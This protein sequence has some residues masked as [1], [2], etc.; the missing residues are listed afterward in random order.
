MLMFGTMDTPFRSQP[1]NRGICG[2]PSAAIRAELPPKLGPRDQKTGVK[3]KRPATDEKSFEVAFWKCDAP[4]WAACAVKWMCADGC[5]KS[6][7][8]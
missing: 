7:N 4:A 1:F 3:T 6:L 8:G 2:Y 5:P